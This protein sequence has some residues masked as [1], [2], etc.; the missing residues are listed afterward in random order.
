MF[1]AGSPSRCCDDPN[2]CRRPRLT[3]YYVGFP[4]GAAGRRAWA[5]AD[6]RLRLPIKACP[7]RQ[8]LGEATVR[9]SSLAF[10]SFGDLLSGAPSPNLRQKPSLSSLR[11]DRLLAFTRLLAFPPGAVVVRPLSS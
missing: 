9:I 4:K 8:S 5:Q 2:G 3:Q 6:T 1:L 10:V 7:A 11:F